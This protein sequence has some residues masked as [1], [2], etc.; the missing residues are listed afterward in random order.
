M[1][2]GDVIAQLA[3]VGA[4][5]VLWWGLTAGGF[6]SPFVLPPPGRVAAAFA[7]LVQRPDTWSNLGWT[8]SAVLASA[9]I[10]VPLGAVIGFA[11]AASDYWKDVLRPILYFP[12]SIPKSVFLPLFIL[13]L[14]IG[15]VQS[16][17]F[18]TF[19]IVFLMVVTSIAAVESVP[20]EYLR[21]ARSYDASLVQT[22]RHVYL[23]SMVPVLLEG[24]RLSMIFGFTGILVAEMYASRGGFGRSLSSWGENFQVD[25]LLAG[26]ILVS[27]V[28][29]GF[30]EAVRA[31]ERRAERWRT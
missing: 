8:V 24:L 27:L 11:T 20:E 23:P 13:T 15:P 1:R 25:Q 4:L 7:E 12:L 30:N 9:A 3:I 22:V 17:A 31:A 19:S 18:G 10:A 26:V 2:V 6:V 14:G 16:I 28:A 29:I 5:V 21:V